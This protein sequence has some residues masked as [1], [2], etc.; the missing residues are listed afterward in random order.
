MLFN[1]IILFSQTFNLVCLLFFQQY[2]LRMN[3]LL[4][5]ILQVNQ[6]KLFLNVI[7]VFTIFLDHVI[8]LLL[9]KFI[10]FRW[11]LFDFVSYH[12]VF[13]IFSV[14]LLLQGRTAINNLLRKYIPSNFELLL[15]LR[16]FSLKLFLFQLLKVVFL[17]LQKFTIILLDHSLW[18]LQS[19]IN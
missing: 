7:C 11:N 16:T 8:L 13:H 17:I 12:E 5:L 9:L 15:Q 6:M 2:H 18:L 3:S 1:Q 4:P 14:K 19:E 10:I